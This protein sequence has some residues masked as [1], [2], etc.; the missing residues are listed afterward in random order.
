MGRA[1]IRVLHL[2]NDVMDFDDFSV[3]GGGGGGKGR[4]ILRGQFKYKPDFL[5]QAQR[6]Q[7]KTNPF[8]VS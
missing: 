1:S 4:E 8:T 6:F 7:P 3:P 5:S 2:R